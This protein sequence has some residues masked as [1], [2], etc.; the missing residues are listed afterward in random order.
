MQLYSALERQLQQPSFEAEL[1]RSQHG[2][3][4]PG[5]VVQP[6]QHCSSQPQQQDGRLRQP[7]GAEGG[8][9]LSQDWWELK[10][11]GEL[12]GELAGGVQVQPLVL[13]PLP[14]PAKRACNC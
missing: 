11:D 5:S 3:A 13:P 4:A 6:E 2:L 7:G 1:A 8:E 9:V 14:M 10:E 12:R